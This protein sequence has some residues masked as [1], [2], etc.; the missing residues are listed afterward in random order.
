VLTS[1]T[2]PD[3]F[4]PNFTSPDL[5]CLVRRKHELEVGFQNLHFEFVPSIDLNP[6]FHQTYFRVKCGRA[7]FFERCLVYRTVGPTIPPLLLQRPADAVLGGDFKP[8]PS[9]WFRFPIQEGEMNYVFMGQFRN[10][11]QGE[12][13]V[14]AKVAHAYDIYDNGTLSTVHFD[15]TGGDNDLDDLILEVAVVKR[16]KR[17][18]VFQ[19]VAQQSK[20]NADFVRD[21]LP[22]L[23]AERRK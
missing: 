17:E 7:G 13:N 14:D 12:W 8:T 11:A 15:D 10:P 20:V 9:D 5:G 18:I 4:F 22:K 6:K 2:L 21:R 16:V 23:L 3:L 19:D 1:S